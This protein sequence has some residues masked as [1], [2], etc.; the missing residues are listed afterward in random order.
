MAEV[1]L[2]DAL[3]PLAP[4]TLVHLGSKSSYIDIATA[5]EMLQPDYL[6]ELTDFW[7]KEFDRLCVKAKLAYD[8]ALRSCNDPEKVKLARIYAEKSAQKK[9]NFRPFY[10][11]KVREMY[12]RFQNDGVVVLVEGDEIGYLWDISEKQRSVEDY[13]K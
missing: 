13:E 9:A 12:G 6:K 10:E 3:K 7:R 2:P 1:L 8:M 11:R 4:D 5:S